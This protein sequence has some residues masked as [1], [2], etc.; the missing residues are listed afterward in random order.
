MKSIKDINFKGR[1]HGSHAL[2][3]TFASQLV[4]EQTPFEVV[5]KLLGHDDEGAISHYVALSTEGLRT[6]SL[7]APAATGK[8]AAYL[9]GKE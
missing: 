1:H 4:A 6:C 5:S 8:F 9:M 3:M 2:R 7:P